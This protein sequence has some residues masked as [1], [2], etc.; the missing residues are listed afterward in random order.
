M[1]KRKKEQ[2]QE[3]RL[4]TR[5][6]HA[7][8]PIDQITIRLSR[9]AW[10]KKASIATYAEGSREKIHVGKDNQR[11]VDRRISLENWIHPERFEPRGQLR[12]ENEARGLEFRGRGARAE[13][14]VVIKNGEGAAHIKRSFRKRGQ[15]KRKQDRSVRMLG[16]RMVTSQSCRPRDINLL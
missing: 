11:K 8:S 13:G 4:K 2:R 5:F 16:D 15:W 10:Q 1:V 6:A 14:R 7:L 12:K 9:S 3:R